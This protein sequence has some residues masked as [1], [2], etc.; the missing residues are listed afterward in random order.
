MNEKTG[1]ALRGAAKALRYGMIAS[2]VMGAITFVFAFLSGGLS[3]TLGLDWVRRMLPVVGALCLVVGGAGLL[4]AGSPR[5]DA[6]LGLEKDE[7][8][9]S[10]QHAMGISWATALIVASVDFFLVGI[11]ADL[12]FLWLT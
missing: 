6:S 9:S 1:R 3:L 2:L 7:A 5:R 8:L 10:F 11:V 12:L 4:F